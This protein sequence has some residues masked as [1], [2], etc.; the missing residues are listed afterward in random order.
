MAAMT[1]QKSA[2]SVKEAQF[3]FG[4]EIVGLHQGKLVIDS[5]TI[6][7]EFLALR[8]QVKI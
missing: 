4:K 2:L 3:P 6:S 1:A 7:R 8:A 5:L